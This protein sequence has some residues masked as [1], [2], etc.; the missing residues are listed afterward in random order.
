MRVVRM[1]RRKGSMRSKQQVGN[2][3]KEWGERK[4]AAC[5]VYELYYQEAFLLLPAIRF[6]K[7]NFRV[8]DS[9]LTLG[10]FSLPT[11]TRYSVLLRRRRR[12]WYGNKKKNK[13]KEEIRFH[14]H[15]CIYIRIRIDCALEENF[16]SFPLFPSH[17]SRNNSL[18]PYN[19]R[20]WA[21][22]QKNFYQELKIEIFGM[23]LIDFLS[24]FS[25]V[26]K[27]LINYW[28]WIF[29]KFTRAAE[30]CLRWLMKFY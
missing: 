25:I 16:A 12:R 7:F 28:L 14:F 19:F 17:S 23:K 3:A 10:L 30:C 20:V 4:F 24:W 26:D 29:S 9:L 18:L 27:S 6:S 2:V 21:S 5:C 1:R 15:A 22:E 8:G 11:S 13:K